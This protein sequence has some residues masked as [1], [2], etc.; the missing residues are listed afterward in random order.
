MATSVSTP[1]PVGG[2]LTQTKVLILE[3]TATNQTR[4]ITAGPSTLFTV[5][6]DNLSSAVASNTKVWVKLT[7]DISDG[8]SPGT[9]KALLGFPVAARTVSS[10]VTMQ[11]LGDYQLLHI[12]AGLQFENGISAFASK[13]AGDLATNPPGTDVGVQLTHS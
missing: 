3:N 13:E 9:T 10:D 12:G 4:N 1:R 2:P 7:D 6:A 5:L 11:F 8:W